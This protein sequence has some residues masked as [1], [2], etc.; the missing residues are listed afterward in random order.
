MIFPLTASFQFRTALALYQV[1]PELRYTFGFAGNML[2]F[3]VILRM[4]PFTNASLFL[5][6]LTVSDFFYLLT[7]CVTRF[8]FDFPEVCVYLITL[9]AMVVIVA[10][11]VVVVT[12]LVEVVVVVVA[13]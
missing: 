1:L 9:R 5:S 10:V 12:V 11:V 13:P 6:I 8:L 3:V 7:N 4:R 2:A